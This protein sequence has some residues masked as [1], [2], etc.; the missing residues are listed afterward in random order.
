M[1]L[2]NEYRVINDFI[3]ILNIYKLLIALIVNAIDVF[4]YGYK[5][6]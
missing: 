2:L 1:Q 4:V 6:S 3:I 5:C